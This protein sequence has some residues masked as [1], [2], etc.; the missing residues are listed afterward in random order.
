LLL[1]T[2]C[3]CPTNP[4]ECERHRLIDHPD[5]AGGLIE[6]KIKD[7]YAIAKYLAAD[8]TNLAVLRQR[9][10]IFN[11]P[12][13]GK[14]IILSDIHQGAFAW[15]HDQ[16]DFFWKN[17]E[18]YHHLLADYYYPKGFTLIEAGD[19]E[20]FWLKRWKKSF[21]EH[22]KYQL[23]T[24]TDLYEI[25][26]KFYKD[27]RYFRLRGNHDNIWRFEDRVQKYLWQ[28]AQLD[29]LKVY[30]FITIGEH[31]LLFHGHQMDPL[32]RDVDCRKGTFW[33]NVGSVLEFFTDTKLFG[34]KRPPSG[35]VEHPQANLIYN[36]KIEY[37]I[38]NKMRL[39]LT[40][41]KL[42]QLL[43][44]VLIAGHTHSPKCMPEGDLTFNQGCGVFEGIQYG[45]ELNFEEDLIRLVDWNDDNGMPDEPQV[46]CK[47]FLSDLRERL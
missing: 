15:S 19:I 27:N 42:A 30:E 23:E 17:K 33:T 7:K 6:R 31:L 9:K 34:I 1:N 4:D 40:H 14:Y 29:Q 38:Y 10:S 2:P 41:A 26:R 25:R 11:V 35:W 47:K 16:Y 37:D 5:Y 21:D 45:I 24:F 8:Y 13:K 22:W 32:N 39:N 12:P 46:L 20:E 28:D 43:N 3:T 44:I 36:R 18:L